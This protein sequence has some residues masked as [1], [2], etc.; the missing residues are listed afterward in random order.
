[1]DLEASAVP[2]GWCLDF[3]NTPTK[4]GGYI[5]LS[6]QGANKFCTLGEMLGWASGIRVTAGEQVSHRC[7]NPRCVVPGH[8]NIE[9][10]KK[11]NNRKG[12]LVWVDCPHCLLK[13]FIC[14]HW[15]PCIR[16]ALGFATEQEFIFNAI[17]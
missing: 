13:I 10:A 3:Q 17:H 11:N 6:W 8:I 7:H 9:S 4:S 5:Q 1:M 15:P 12:C 2:N 16:A 14:P